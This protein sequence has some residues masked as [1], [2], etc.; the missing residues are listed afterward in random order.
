MQELSFQFFLGWWFSVNAPTKHIASAGRGC[1]T[2][3]CVKIR[4]ILPTHFLR[5]FQAINMLASSRLLLLL[6]ALLACRHAASQFTTGQATWY[7]DIDSG[8]CGFF[9][10]IPSNGFVAAWPFVETSPTGGFWQPGVDGSACGCA[11][12][13]S[14]SSWSHNTIQIAFF[15]SFCSRPVVALLV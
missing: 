8:F 13:S 2:T 6:A 5:R 4:T 12:S 7:D 9:G 1:S 11:R 10:N 14:L 15:S 3:Q